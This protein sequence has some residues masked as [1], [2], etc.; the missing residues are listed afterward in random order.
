MMMFSVKNQYIVHF[1]LSEKSAKSYTH[2]GPKLLKIIPE[3]KLK[4]NLSD[5][6]IL[7]LKS[8]LTNQKQEILAYEP[9]KYF[10]RFL[11]EKSE[12]ALC[13]NSRIW[14]FEVHLHQP[15]AKGERSCATL[16]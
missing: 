9:K 13:L 16:S 8:L 7:V 6:S 1:I 14:R 12:K 11:S 2:L 15:R 4:S 10:R 3:L 5:W